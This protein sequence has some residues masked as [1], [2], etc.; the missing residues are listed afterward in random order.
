MKSEGLLSSAEE[1][2]ELAQI[3][4]QQEVISFD[5]E[6]IREST[7][8]PIVEIIQVA[9]AESSWLIDAQAFKK[10]HSATDPH[11]YDP[12]IQPLLDVFTDPKILKIL[13]AAQGDQECLYTSFGVVASPTLDT[14]VAASLCGLGDGIGLSK[15]LKL[16]LDVTLMKGHAR[17][18]WSV[19]PLP[20]QLIDYAHADV[21][22]LVTLAKKLLQ[23]LERLDRKAWA[24]ELSAHWEDKSLYQVDVEAMAQK[25]ARSGRL[26]KKGYA[27]L[28]EL[29][30]WR[31]NRVRQLNL[32]RKWIADDHVLIDLAHVRPKEMSHLS[33]F[34]GL[35]KGELKHSGEAILAAIKKSAEAEDV[36]LPKMMKTAVASAEES[37]ALELIKCFVGVLA[38]HHKIAA[39]HLLTTSKLL[40]LLRTPLEKPDD[41]VQ[42]GILGAEASSLI[43]AELISMLKGNRALKIQNGEV[44]VIDTP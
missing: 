2:I 4:R 42:S 36:S 24:L 30:Q 12:G 8:F 25:L 34:R 13:H 16:V 19:R 5:T 33:A 27:A 21:E 9:T 18:N 11:A 1:I 44:Q 26:D 10:K 17:T 3:L 6:F 15:L 28:V 20:H 31:E 14:A 32:P 39:K 37:Q 35:N 41:L 7:F 38:D 22:F 40:M 23:D 29:V 43:G